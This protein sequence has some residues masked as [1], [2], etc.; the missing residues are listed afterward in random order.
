[1]KKSN[2]D[3]NNISFGE[4]KQEKCS[5]KRLLVY[6]KNNGDTTLVTSLPNND[7]T[8]VYIMK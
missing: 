5:C 6:F 1:M 4:T 7:L 3:N 2:S 8:F